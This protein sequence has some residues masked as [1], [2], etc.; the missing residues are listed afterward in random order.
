MEANDEIMRGHLS[1]RLTLTTEIKRHGRI[2]NKLLKKRQRT[3]GDKVILQV[4]PIYVTEYTIL[5]WKNHAPARKSPVP[6]AKTP[7]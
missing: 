5:T 6:E 3:F 2:I 4:I 1:G 7:F